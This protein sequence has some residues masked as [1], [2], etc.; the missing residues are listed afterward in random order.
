MVLFLSRAGG[1]CGLHGL[2]VLSRSICLVWALCGSNAA[3]ASPDVAPP[4]RAALRGSAGTAAADDG[5]RYALKTGPACSDTRILG[6]RLPD[7]ATVTAAVRLSID[8]PPCGGEI[9]ANL[10]ANAADGCCWHPG[11]VN[12]RFAA[13]VDLGS[14]R[15]G[16][17]GLPAPNMELGTDLRLLSVVWD[18]HKSVMGV[19]VRPAAGLGSEPVVNA[20]G[21]AAAY[22][23]AAY[24]QDEW[25]LGPSLTAVLGLQLDRHHADI[26]QLRPRAGL[27]WRPA[28]DTVL[29]ARYGRAHRGFSLGERTDDHHL[30][31]NPLRRLEPIEAYELDTEQ[32][33][34]R[35]LK[36]HAVLY[37]MTVRDLSSLALGTMGGLPQVQADQTVQARGLA[38]SADQHWAAAGVRLRGSA[39]WQDPTDAH[40]DALL[41]GPQL[42]GKVLLSAP[43][44]WVGLRLDYEWLYDADRIAVD[45]RALGAYAQSNLSLD[46]AE[47]RKGLAL[48]LMVQNL[49][50]TRDPRLVAANALDAVEQDRRRVRVRLSYQF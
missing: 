38:L 26:T 14:G 1:A 45:G 4:V 39:S 30:D 35:D 44:P 28:A 24:A 13:P 40:G 2:R 9:G 43:L 11:S 19:T 34:G 12:L 41:S 20:P 21:V 42:L 7:E 48:S 22:Q 25:H 47:L 6:W 10:P 37:A 15:A 16:V 23:V 17:L 5:S 27:V 49:F 50:D 29:K 3:L 33:V 8:G 36:L 46:G 32:R 18:G 31:A